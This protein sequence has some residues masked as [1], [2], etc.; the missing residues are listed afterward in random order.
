MRL[1]LAIIL[2]TSLSSCCEV[3]YIP[4][5]LSKKLPVPLTP[6]NE[7]VTSDEAKSLSIESRDRIILG[8]RRIDTLIR[9]INSTKKESIQP[10]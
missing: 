8:E 7:V 1:I 6:L 2:L 10:Q 5:D 9:I 4:V 3:R